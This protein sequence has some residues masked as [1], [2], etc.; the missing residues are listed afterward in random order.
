[1]LLQILL[2]SVLLGDDPRVV[3]V[4]QV[5]VIVLQRVVICRRMIRGRRRRHR[6][7]AAL[8]LTILRVVQLL[9]IEVVQREVGGMLMSRR[10]TR[11]ATIPR[12]E[13]QHGTH[14]GGGTVVRMLRLR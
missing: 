13:R 9:V 11:S 2:E 7:D 8:V 5:D 10:V 3:V 6:C 4:V 14:G 12:T 1:M